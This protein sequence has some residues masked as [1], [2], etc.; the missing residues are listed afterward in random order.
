MKEVRSNF[1]R[2]SNNLGLYDVDGN[3]ETTCMSFRHT[4]I[5]T[6]KK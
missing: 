2:I 4:F 3:K 1:E 6:K 5:T